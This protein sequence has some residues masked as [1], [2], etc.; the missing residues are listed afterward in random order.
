MESSNAGGDGSLEVI[1]DEDREEKTGMFGLRRRKKE[2]SKSVKVVDKNSFNLSSDSSV[3][4]SN[5]KSIITEK[6]E[7]LKIRLY[8]THLK[9]RLC[10]H[11]KTI[12]SDRE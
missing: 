9:K 10:N 12:Y 3:K 5:T 4:N 1:I 8:R 2:N 7:N 11:M 6:S